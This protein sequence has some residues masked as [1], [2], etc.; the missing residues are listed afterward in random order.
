ME[1][2]F[3]GSNKISQIP[4][5]LNTFPH[6][7]LANQGR[8]SIMTDTSHFKAVTTAL[9]TN[10]AKWTCSYCKTRKYPTW[11]LASSILSIQ[12]TTI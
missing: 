4:G 12:N 8:W 5:M 3:Y 10:L 9:E 6:K 11:P 1:A 7:G 2:M